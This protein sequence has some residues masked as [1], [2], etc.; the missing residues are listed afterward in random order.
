MTTERGPLTAA[1]THPG[2]SATS[3]SACSTPK[4]TAIIAPPGGNAPISR[5]LTATSLAASSTDSTP[6]RQA[7]A[8]SPTLWPMPNTGRIPLCSNVFPSA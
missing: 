5:P 1:I 8:T 4:S 3:A 7:A 6:A 2:S